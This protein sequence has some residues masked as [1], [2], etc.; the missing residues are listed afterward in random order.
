MQLKLKLM[1][2]VKENEKY[3]RKERDWPHRL[4]EKRC[5]QLMERGKPRLI[6]KEI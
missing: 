4:M 3:F 2:M 1:V 5:W 6:L